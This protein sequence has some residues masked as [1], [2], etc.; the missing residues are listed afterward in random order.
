[1]HAAYAHNK[2]S[3][4][5]AAIAFFAIGGTA[6][7]SLVHINRMLIGQVHKSSRNLFQVLTFFCF[8]FVRSFVYTTEKT[9]AARSEKKINFSGRFGRMVSLLGIINHSIKIT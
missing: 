2:F 4:T 9:K 1:M 3:F 7:L 8:F 6:L 5:F